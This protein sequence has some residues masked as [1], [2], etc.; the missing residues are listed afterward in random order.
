MPSEPMG[1]LTIA[2][3]LTAIE[4]LRAEM[5]ERLDALQARIAQTEE[6]LQRD[7]RAYGR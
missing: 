1:E 5:T 7:I 6:R 4:Q 2:D 3:L